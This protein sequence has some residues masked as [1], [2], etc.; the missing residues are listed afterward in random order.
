MFQI[1]FFHDLK[2]NIEVLERKGKEKYNFIDA[3]LSDWV[4]VLYGC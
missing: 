3:K 2:Y 1:D 4:G